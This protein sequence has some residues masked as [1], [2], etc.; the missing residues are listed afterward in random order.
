MMQKCLV[1]AFAVSAAVSVCSLS[2]ALLGQTPAAAPAFEVAT[3]RPAPPIQEIIQELQSGKPRVGMA[4]DGA[5]VNMGFQSLADL[6]EDRSGWQRRRSHA[7]WRRD[8]QTIDIGCRSSHGN[9][10]DKLG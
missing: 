1:R 3:M 7:E 9:D 2:G 4:I 10:E 5:R 6:H 8:H